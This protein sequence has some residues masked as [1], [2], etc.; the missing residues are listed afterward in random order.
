M[1]IL[2]RDRQIVLSIAQFGQLPSGHI[3]VMHFNSHK[4]VTPMYR[5]L[6]RLVAFRYIKRLERRPIGGNGSGSGQ[7]VYQLGSAGWALSGREG[8]YW[9]TRSV[10]HHTIGIADAYL[11]LLYL[12]HQGRLTIDTVTTEPDTWRVIAGAD[13]RPDLHVEVSDI[14]RQR[15]LSLWL[16]IDL[17]T[18]RESA[19]KD[20]LARYLHAFENADSET[21]PVFPLVVF[22]APDDA[23]ARWLRSVVERGP[24]DAQALFLVSTMSEF[25]PLIFS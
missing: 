2:D 12:Q 20:K 13:L 9:P 23:R 14:G 5:A 22:I 8:R 15:Y 3:K 10:N 24:K 1:F 6:D 4:S 18:E 7:Y 21:L 17:G 25:A 11:E 19:I 16:E